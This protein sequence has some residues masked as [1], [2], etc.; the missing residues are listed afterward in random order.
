MSITS[1]I[2]NSAEIQSWLLTEL[3]RASTTTDTYSA[4]IACTLKKHR[5]DSTQVPL[6]RH[7]LRHTA[8]VKTAIRILIL[9]RG[10]SEALAA[11]FFLYYIAGEQGMEVCVLLAMLSDAG[12]ESIQVVRPV[13]TERES[14]SKLS[15]IVATFLRNISHLFFD[16]HCVSQGYTKHMLD[17]L[18]T[19]LVYTVKGNLLQC[20]CSRGVPQHVI[21]T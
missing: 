5:F 1:I 12:D 8:I 15:Y 7:V 10:K 17:T 21:D 4:D 20:G 11:G 16:G 13:D 14:A 18:K 2:A 6:A 9:R 3:R 19:P